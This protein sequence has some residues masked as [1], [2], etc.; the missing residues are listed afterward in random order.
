MK[1]DTSE[2]LDILIAKIVQNSDLDRV[3][4]DGFIQ[5]VIDELSSTGTPTTVGGQ[6]IHKFL[7]IK[8]KSNDI[9]VKLATFLQRREEKL[10][11]TDDVE[12]DLETL[13]EENSNSTVP[14]PKEDL[15]K[16]GQD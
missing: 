4:A 8:T 13:Y 14:A 9:L 10:K 16:N 15:D 6:T 11:D 2:M 5:D 7:E 1:K 12:F 3:M